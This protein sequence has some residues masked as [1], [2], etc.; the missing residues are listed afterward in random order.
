M[1]PNRRCGAHGPFEVLC[2]QPDI[3]VNGGGFREAEAHVLLRLNRDQVFHC[4]ESCKSFFACDMIAPLVVE[5]AHSDRIGRY[6][7]PSNLVSDSRI[8]R[9]RSE[10]L[11]NLNIAYSARS[12]GMGGRRAAVYSEQ[13]DAEETR[14]SQPAAQPDPG[15]RSVFLSISPLRHLCH[16]RA[17]F[18]FSQLPE[19]R[20]MRLLSMR[21]DLLEADCISAIIDGGGDGDHRATTSSARC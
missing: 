3:V 13:Q 19:R 2:M 16:H 15:P 5:N 18:S 1:N 6:V 12:S 8:E 4:S 20:S 14:H 7:M 11:A 9:G 10:I 17:H 21:G